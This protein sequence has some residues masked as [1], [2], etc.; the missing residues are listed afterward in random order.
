MRKSFIFLF[1]ILFSLLCT[2]FVQ[3]ISYS[4]S[5]EDEET[6]TKSEVEEMIQKAVDEAVAPLQ[7][8]IDTLTE[9]LKE[10]QTDLQTVSDAQHQ[11]AKDDN[12]ED[13]VDGAI[14]T[15]QNALIDPVSNAIVD[16]MQV[17]NDIKDQVILEAS[18]DVLG[19]KYDTSESTSGSCSGS[20]SVTG[21]PDHW[22][23]PP[24]R[25]CDIRSVGKTH[26]SLIQHTIVHKGCLI[27]L[28][29]L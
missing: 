11:Y 28:W 17:A 21:W 18:D 27:P 29:V 4:D 16:G 13:I 2:S 24:S 1:L 26:L 3:N 20:C 6:F 15:A 22:G 7:E 12:A 9:G 23:S 5:D 19:S 10:T 14:D 25:S 8:Q